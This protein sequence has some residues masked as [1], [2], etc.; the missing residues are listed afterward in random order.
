M[1]TNQIIK[2]ADSTRDISSQIIRVFLDNKGTYEVNDSIH[3]LMEHLAQINNAAVIVSSFFKYS[4]KEGGV[5]MIDRI[6]QEEG[7]IE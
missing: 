6:G 2:W 3:R 5:L 7:A 4:F 1:D